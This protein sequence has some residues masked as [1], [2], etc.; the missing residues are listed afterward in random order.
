MK[1]LFTVL[2]FISI[3]SCQEETNQ[4]ASG[5]AIFES[6]EFYSVIDGQEKEFSLSD[7][8]A[9]WRTAIF[10]ET[11]IEPHFHNYRIEKSPDKNGSTYWLFAEAQNHCIVIAT[12]LVREKN[13]FRVDVQNGKEICGCTGCEDDCTLIFNDGECICQKSSN[14]VTTCSGIGAAKNAE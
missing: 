11:L 4:F 14:A 13:R 12:R 1:Q 7:F 10:K 2:L 9:A 3:I 6:E 8:E 5:L